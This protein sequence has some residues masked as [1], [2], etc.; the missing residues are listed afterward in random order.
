MLNVEKLTIE[1][2]YKD[3]IGC[4][5][6]NSLSRAYETSSFFSFVRGKDV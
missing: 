1:K 5:K 6:C 4:E 2:S 3:C